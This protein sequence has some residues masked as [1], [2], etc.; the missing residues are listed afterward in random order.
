MSKKLK[1][2]LLALS[3]T[4]ITSISIN[5]ASNSETMKKYTRMNSEEIT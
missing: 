5:A 1:I 3:I 4:T 2:I